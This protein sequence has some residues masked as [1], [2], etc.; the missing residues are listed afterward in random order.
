[1]S[2]PETTQQHFK[3]TVTNYNFHRHFSIEVFSNLYEIVI[4]RPPQWFCD[5]TKPEILMYT[6]TNS[7]IMIV[8]VRR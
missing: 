3:Q 1:M 7:G 6:L 2:V 8:M 5:C 4:C